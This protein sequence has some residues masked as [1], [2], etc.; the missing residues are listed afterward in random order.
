DHSEF[1]PAQSWCLDS[2]I[3]PLPGLRSESVGERRTEFLPECRLRHNRKINP[4]AGFLPLL[5]DRGRALLLRRSRQPDDMCGRWC[6]RPFACIGQLTIQLRREL[7][8]HQVY[9]ISGLQFA[10]HVLRVAPD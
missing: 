3:Q 7:V 8:A 4:A 9:G 5:Y 10:D 1:S 6:L 2:R